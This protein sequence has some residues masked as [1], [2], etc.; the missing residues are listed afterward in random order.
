MEY[1]TY[2]GFVQNKTWNSWEERMRVKRRFRVL[3]DEMHE[4]Y[5]GS[6]ISPVFVTC[7]SSCHQVLREHFKPTVVLI[8]EAAIG[9]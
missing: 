6:F 1:L 4:A 8:E 3:E 9:K 2:K 7:S 5:L